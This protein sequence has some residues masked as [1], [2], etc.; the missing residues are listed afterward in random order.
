MISFERELRDHSKADIRR[1]V[2]CGGLNPSERRRDVRAAPG[3]ARAKLLDR[4]F[5]GRGDPEHLERQD[6]REPV[7]SRLQQRR[8]FGA[9][10]RRSH[11][12]ALALDL[13]GG[14]ERATA[15]NV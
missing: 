14:R 4:P 1:L 11:L 2:E 9:R 7:G 13:H 6:D 12:V 8:S 10:K 3:D 15:P 5:R